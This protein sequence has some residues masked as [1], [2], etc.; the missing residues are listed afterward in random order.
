MPLLKEDMGH[1]MGQTFDD[2]P[3]DHSDF[4]I[5]GMDAIASVNPD[6]TQGERVMGDYQRRIVCGS[7]GCQSQ[8][9]VRQGERLLGFVGRIADASGHELDLLRHLKVLEGG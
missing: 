6:L 1:M 8:P 9:V 3:L 5:R 2:E 7:H 4:A